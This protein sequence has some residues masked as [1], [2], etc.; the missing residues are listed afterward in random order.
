VIVGVGFA[1][2]FVESSVF[3]PVLSVFI[4]PLEAEFGWTRTMIA[5]ATTVGALAGVIVSPL[6]GRFIDRY[7]PRPFL[8]VGAGLVSVGLFS[9]AFTQELWQFYVGFGLGRMTA[10]SITNLANTV[11]VSNWFIRRRGSAIGIMLLGERIGQSMLPVIL[12]AIIL[13]AGWRAAWVFLGVAGI[14]LTLMPALFL[15]RRRPEDYG[16][17][18]DG[19]RVPE[20]QAPVSSTVE[21]NWTPREALRTRAFWLVTIAMATFFLVG[22][23]FNL[24]MTA[25]WQDRGLSLEEAVSALAVYSLTGAFGSLAWGFINDRVGV[26]AT[27]AMCLFGGSACV[28]LLLLSDTLWIAL[29]FGATYGFFVGGIFTLSGVVFPAYFGRRSQGAIRGLAVPLIFAG[30]AFGPVIAGAAYDA[31][32]NYNAVFAAFGLLMVAAGGCIAL[33][34]PPRR[35]TPVTA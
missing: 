18:P 4:L 2:T 25:Y 26:R 32:G 22:A 1:F 10:M 9:L 35:S 28:P 29:I 13:S 14:V 5:G 17:L 11:A 15:V 27:Y 20:G 8:V 7:G 12:T 19:E 33:A 6:I 31:I 23:A 3:N 34:R 21:E 24:H 30:N 16:L